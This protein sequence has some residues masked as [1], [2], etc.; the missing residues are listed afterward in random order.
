MAQDLPY[1]GVTLSPNI[2]P[3]TDWYLRSV[4]KSTANTPTTTVPAS[5]FTDIGG[6]TYSFTTRYGRTYELGRIES[7]EA[8]LAVDNTDGLFD[9][10]NTSGALYPNVV[11]YR[12]L[13]IHCAYPR[14][15]NILNDGNLVPAWSANAPTPLSA[16]RISVGKND[17]DFE[18]GA[19]SNWYVTTGTAPTVT[20]TAHSGTYA[21]SCANATTVLLDVPVV[22]GQV[23]TVSIWY[24]FSGATTTGSLNLYDG[25]WTTSSATATAT[26]CAIQH[27]DLHASQRHLHRG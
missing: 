12:P 23:V 21:M 4:T 19:I 26:A 17:G 3:N 24:R 5:L 2:K 11:P 18:L 1:V 10:L 16:Y 27:H 22:A 25:G 13:N 8:Q 15:G 7:G 9:P 14:T 6:R 20:T